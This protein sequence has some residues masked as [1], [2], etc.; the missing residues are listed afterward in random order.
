MEM[1]YSYNFCNHIKYK[2]IIKLKLNFV[3]RSPV[4]NI[5]LN[6]HKI[7]FFNYGI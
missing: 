7:E 1:L 2:M 5:L 3:L 6:V 4:P